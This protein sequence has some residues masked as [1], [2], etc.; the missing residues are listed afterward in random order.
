MSFTLAQVELLKEPLLRSNV[1]TRSQS[2]MNLS[3]VEGYYVIEQANEVFGFDGWIGEVVS[4]N[5]VQQTETK[6]DDKIQNRV[7]YTC[8]YRIN[9]GGVIREDIGFGNG[10]DADAGKAHESA[11]K[12]A[13]TDAMK[14]CLRTFGYRF[15]LA[16]YGKKQENVVTEVKKPQGTSPWK[17]ADLAAVKEITKAIGMS[18]ADAIKV[19]AAAGVKTDGTESAKAL[20]AVQEHVIKVTAT[21]DAPGKAS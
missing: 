15:G 6:K 2:G 11:T 13:V 20:K 9:V 18:G 3:Y 1:S 5:L 10:I 4:L 7:A 8:V 21:D 12:E 17:G 19:V 16:L 14:R